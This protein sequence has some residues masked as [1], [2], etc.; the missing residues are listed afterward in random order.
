[1]GHTL[2]LLDLE[3]DAVRG[4]SLA[5]AQLLV[6]GAGRT[7][8]AVARFTHA[9]GA[10]VTIHDSAASEKTQ[11]IGA[12]LAPLGI[13]AV[14]GETAE[15]AELFAQ[16]DL[17]IHSP[18]VTLGFPTVAPSVLGPLEAFAKAAL[19]L[20]GET[21]T[22]GKILIS[23]PEWTSRLLGNRWRVGVTGTKGKTSTSALL[24]AILAT[25]PQHPVAFGG[26]NG[27]PLI[28][29]VLE[30]PESVR[31]VLELS[32]LQLPTMYG[33]ID[34][35]VYTNVTADHLDRHGSVESY[36]RVKQRL[37]ALINEAGTLIVNLDDPVTA[38]Y[39]G[40]GR[41]AT[42][43]YRRDAPLP[44]G[45]GVVDGWIIAAGVQRAARY[46]GGAAATGPGGRIMPVGEIQMP[47]DHSISNVLAAVSAALVAGIAPDAIRKA[48]A[49]FKGVP[50]RLEPVGTIDGIQFIND[51]QATQPDAVIAALNTFRKPLILLA[52]GR[53]K[54]ADLRALTAVVGERCSGA[55]LFG[56][57][58]DELE[59]LF[60]NAGV[61]KIE[62]AA[63]ID[64]AARRGFNLARA[65]VGAKIDPGFGVEALA[66]VLLSPI[67]SS[68]DMFNNPFGARGDAFRD[69]VKQMRSEV[70]A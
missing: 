53:S 23:E 41:V 50:H 26:N 9:A 14:F 43:T 38:A 58:A 21:G 30:M 4:G 34:V 5:G 7:G 10:L 66:T 64:D 13:R 61:T 35:G 55:V 18:S 32:E 24:A 16:A 37:A 44:G 59:Q 45:V 25:D 52:G 1:M 2:R 67:G 36:R 70:Q 54:G 29:R 31:V 20:T 69:A 6:L 22:P 68:Y 15:L 39:A 12:A 49:G 46:G 19:A 17:V 47:G 40:E 28:E 11:A 48:V 33:A 27:A 57:L 60:R 3:A 51:G 62:R 63:T 65:A 42:V 56:E 8:E